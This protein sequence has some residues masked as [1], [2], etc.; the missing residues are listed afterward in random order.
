[1]SYPLR[2]NVGSFK[3][4]NPILSLFLAFLAAV[5]SEFCPNII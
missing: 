1:M 4:K 2:Q 3:Q 5:F